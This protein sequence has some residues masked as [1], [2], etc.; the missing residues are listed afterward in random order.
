MTRRIIMLVAAAVLSL[1]PVARGQVTKMMS[2]TAV[3]TAALAR[4]LCTMQ[5]ELGT[6]TLEGLAVCITTEPPVFITLSLDS[7]IPPGS[8]DKFL[9]VPANAPDK[10][11][12]AELLGIDPE[13][14]IGFL[15]AVEPY[16]WSI[17]QFAPKANLAV[18]QPVSSLG[19]LGRDSDYQPY[20]GLAYISA[21]LHVPEEVGYVSG[22]RLT[23]PGSPV[24]NSD[25][26]AI[27]LV[28]PQRFMNYQTV[29]GGRVT[30]FAL[31]G[32]E[33]TSFF[34]PVDEFAHVL[35]NIPSS[36]G[37]VRRLPWIGVLSFRGVEPE[38]GEIMKLES[39]GVTLDGVVP[40]GP[41]AKAGLEDRDVVTA[42]NGEKL[43]FMADPDLVATALQ[44]RLFR[45]SAGQKVMLSIRRA[46]A[47]KD[48]EVTL[49]P[50]PP[51]PH[52]VPRYLSREYGF[53]AREKVELDKSLDRSPA[54]AVPGLIVLAVDEMA[55][56]A[57]LGENDVITNAN[58]VPVTTVAALKEAS[59]ATAKVGKPLEVVIRRGSETRS[60][61]LTAHAAA[62]SAPS[63]GQ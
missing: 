19:L 30:G 54:A 10:R 63:T 2:D 26:R 41:A 38:V 47:A 12:K 16:T 44:R 7:R 23:A 15:K 27:G 34:L 5:D 20:V 50:M 29:V 13:T 9:L 18:G 3:Q 32:Q 8:L 22:G 62:V 4:F 59:E 21:I 43:P 60:V 6:R 53:L 17:V 48:I 61:T 57:G 56:K 31:R 24:F 37:Q 33:E 28:S 45:M 58:N 14:N 51:L 40:G 11:V 25:G 55:A 46:D 42:V 36:P 1:T 52:E 49:E 35:V 39:P